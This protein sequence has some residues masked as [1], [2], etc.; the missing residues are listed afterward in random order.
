[1]QE[2]WVQFL[3]WEDPLEKGKATHSSIL[4]GEFHGLCSPRDC[5]ES[6]TTERLSPS[7]ALQGTTCVLSTPGHCPSLSSWAV[8][9]VMERKPRQKSITATLPALTGKNT[10]SPK[11]NIMGTS[12][13]AVWFYHYFSSYLNGSSLTIKWKT[14]LWYLYDFFFA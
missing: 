13:P 9:G 3:G 12:T 6:D 2:T 14:L 8:P 7:L 4:P 11:E 10:Q 1:M 5:K